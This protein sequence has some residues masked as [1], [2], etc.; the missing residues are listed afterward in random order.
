MADLSI[1]AGK[2]ASILDF[3]LTIALVIVGSV[4]LVVAAFSGDLKWFWPKFNSMPSQ[5]VVLCHGHE[6]RLE[7]TSLEAEALALLMN[8][9]LSGDKRFDPL[10]LTPSTYAYYRSDPAV[11]TLELV[12]AAPVRIHLPNK[13]FTNITSLL[14]PLQ[15]RYA[16]SSILF[17]LIDGVPAGGSLHLTSIQPVI[18]RLASTGLCIIP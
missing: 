16:N 1:S 15:G 3:L 11:V 9:Q 10:N 14:I 5:V 17:G 2:K 12:Y 8:G 18:D 6:T 13:Y 7:G 4:Y